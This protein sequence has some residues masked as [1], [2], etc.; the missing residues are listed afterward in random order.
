M[1]TWMI[2]LSVALLLGA[3]GCKALKQVGKH[4]FV[5]GVWAPQ[6]IVIDGA[7]ED[8]ASPYP[9]FDSKTH[10]A[11]ATANDAQYLYITMMTGDELAQA[12]VLQG[13]MHVII[14]TSGGKNAPF[15]VQYPMENDNSGIDV[16]SYLSLPSPMRKTQ[17]VQQIVDAIDKANQVTAVGFAGCEGGY[18]AQKTMPCGIQVTM[19]WSS[20]K[21]LI[22]EAKIPFQLLYGVPT[23]NASYARKPISVCYYLK[24]VKAPKGAAATNNT[25]SLSNAAGNVGMGGQSGLTAGMQPSSNPL[26]GY[27][28]ASRTYKFFELAFMDKK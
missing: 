15:A 8:W 19:K 24:G 25:G 6:T 9:N 10:L 26:D 2:P 7:N 20:Y 13:G 4:S 11:Y 28:S 14:D 12:K 17:L 21:E 18:M 3:V 1:R 5:P 27:Y 22:W 23:I 16:T